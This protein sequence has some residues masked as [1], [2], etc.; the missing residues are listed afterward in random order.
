[1]GLEQLAGEERETYPYHCEKNISDTFFAGVISEVFS[2]RLEASMAAFNAK[3]LSPSPW[4]VGTQ[5]LSWSELEVA[6]GEPCNLKTARKDPNPNRDE[7]PF[8]HDM[9]HAST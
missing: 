1:M 6:V 7:R 2:A 3:M 8:C 5:S 4:V 9:P